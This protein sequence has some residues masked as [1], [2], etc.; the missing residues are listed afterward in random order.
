VL[1]VDEVL[2]VGD[3]GFQQKCMA[4]MEEFRRNG[5]AIVFVS[6]NM[7]AI[8]NLCSKALL[9][10]RGKV[11]AAGTP[12]EV[13]DTYTNSTYSILSEEEH[14]HLAMEIVAAEICDSE[15]RTTRS[16]LS[17]ECGTIKLRVRARRAIED[18]V[19]GIGVRDSDATLIYGTNSLMLKTPVGRV[20]EGEEIVVSF[21]LTL[22]LCQGT[23]TIHAS[24]LPSEPGAIMDW[25][26]NLAAFEMFGDQTGMGSADLRASISIRRARGLATRGAS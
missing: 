2:S 17:G 18:P 23:Y 21:P 22:N 26:E 6:H 7:S 12:R 24:A 20:D 25:R 14:E 15:E 19:I 9:L 8:M 1:L 10:Q 5:V 4:K 3:Y 11:M 13:V 16:F